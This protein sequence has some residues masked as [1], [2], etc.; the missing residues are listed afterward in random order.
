LGPLLARRREVLLR[1]AAAALEVQ[2]PLPGAQTEYERAREA[3]A[4]L[5]KEIERAAVTARPEP[6]AVGV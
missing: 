4:A 3:L 2:A 5:K 1:L 6:V